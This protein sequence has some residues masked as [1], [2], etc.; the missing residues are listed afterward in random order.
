MS[1]PKTAGA[2]TRRNCSSSCSRM[3]ATGTASASLWLIPWKAVRK[4]A[5]DE[6]RV[7]VA[8][9]KED[10]RESKKGEPTN[11]TSLSLLFP[12]LL[13]G[14]HRRPVG[15]SPARNLRSRKKVCHRSPPAARNQFAAEFAQRKTAHDRLNVSKTV[16]TCTAWGAL[17]TP[18]STSCRRVE[19]TASPRSP[20]PSTSS[21][22]PPGRIAR[23]SP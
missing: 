11:L 4:C 7:S 1:R 10:H 17:G 23:T 22:P 12:A 19:C 6:C 13:T 18:C 5:R 2:S 8:Q 21:A 15:V 20:P 9:P 16:R 14:H 3:R